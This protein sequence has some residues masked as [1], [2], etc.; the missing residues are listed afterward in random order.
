MLSGLE[1]CLKTEIIKYSQVW[2][3]CFKL[4]YIAGQMLWKMTRG[5]KSKL[6]NPQKTRWIQWICISCMK[7][8]RAQR[9]GLMIITAQLLLHQEESKFILSLFNFYITIYKKKWRYW[10]SFCNTLSSVEALVF[11]D[12]KYICEFPK[13][14]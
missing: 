3:K 8:V 13:L 7:D 14:K 9:V 6:W 12:A 5:R 4:W 10:S 11:H 1:D 2:F